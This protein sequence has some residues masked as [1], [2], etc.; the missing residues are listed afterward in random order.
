MHV[1]V[2]KEVAA[3]QRMTVKELR[4][5]YAELF[6]E[7]ARTGNKAWLV[8]RLAW[9]L[10]A[11]AEGDLS[12]RARQRAAELACDA[13][14][15]VTPPRARLATTA[16]EHPHSAVL[17]FAA[18]GRLPPPGSVLTR[19]YK[20]TTLRVTVLRHGFEFEGEVYK[21]LSAVAKAISGSHCNGFLFF[22]VGGKGGHA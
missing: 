6:G 8:K 11:L 19:V 10:Q 1:N 17:P 9:R 5:R 7:E 13:D 20:G 15:R 2:G 21:S 14:L 22:R 4:G 16:P 3:L 12:D 18:D